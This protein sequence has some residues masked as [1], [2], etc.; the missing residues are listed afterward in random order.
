[1]TMLFIV[2]TGSAISIAADSKQFPSGSL[3]NK[4]AVVGSDAVIADT[5]LA[6]IPSENGDEGWNVR[7]ELEELHSHPPS[8][9]FFEQIAAIRDRFAEK[10]NRALPHVHELLPVDANLSFFFTKRSGGKS[11]FAFQKLTVTGIGSA[12]RVFAEP[13]KVMEAPYVGWSTPKGCEPSMEQPFRS[14]PVHC[15]RSAIAV[16]F[17]ADRSSDFGGSHR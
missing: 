7:M 5:G 13:L 1:M 8:G 11:F 17:G 3:T 15:N 14:G 2:L 4:L 10:L 16:L 9:G 6:F 12:R